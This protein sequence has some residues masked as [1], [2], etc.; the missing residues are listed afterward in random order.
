M[1]NPGLQYTMDKKYIAKEKKWILKA[2]ENPTELA[3]RDRIATSLGISPI[4]AELL[5]QRGYKN[6][7]SAKNFLYMENEML[8][9][10]FDMKDMDKAVER[11]KKAIDNNEIITVYGDY[12]V[13]G[14][15]SV[16]TL[17]LYL[18]HKGARVSY[19]IPNRA[20]DGYGVSCSAI[21]MLKKNGTSLII[22][23]D[24]GITAIDEVAY[25]KSIGVDF[26]ITDHHECRVDLPDAC[27]VINPHR[28]DC[29]YPFKELAGV[30]V[31]FKLVSAYEERIGGVSKSTAASR[32]FSQYADLVAIGTIADV[33]PIKEENRIIVSYGLKMIEGTTRL[34]L[35]ALMEAAS[36]RNDSRDKPDKKRKRSKITTSYIGYTLAPRINAAGRIRSATLAVELFLSEDPVESAKIANELCLANKERQAE[37]NKIMEEAYEKIESLGMDKDSV[38][39]L[40]ADG[41]HHGVIGIVASRITEKYSRPTIL[42]SFDSVDG[43]QTDSDVGKG[44]GRSIKGL[45]LVDALYHCSEHLVKFGGHELAAGLSVTRGSLEQ[46]RKKIN[47]YANESLDEDAMIPTLE[48]DCRVNLNEISIGLAENLQILEPFGVGNPVPVFAMYNVNL[49]EIT[50]VSENKHS[51]LTIGEGRHTVSAMYFSNSPDSIGVYNG[52]RVDLMFNLD[53]NEWQGRRSVQLVVKDIRQAV[54]LN[55]KKKSEKARFNEIWQGAQYT[56][57]ENVLPCRDDFAVVYKF[58]FASVRGGQDTLTSREIINGISKIHGAPTIGYV[59]I[60]IILKVFRELNIIG[61]DELSDESY[62]FKV[63]YSSTKTDLEKS[64]LLR[65]I[66]SQLITKN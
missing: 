21:D 22:T 51:R 62:R 64:T 42:I 13:D 1:P 25:A 20:G 59:K 45:N 57:D 38:I 36:S 58:I 5:Y 33:M 29:P 60:K 8:C 40:D 19:Y 65:R 66:R 30:G 55:E 12:D 53:I 28:F 15:T 41:W 47:E 43:N 54:T 48:A 2:L 26:L 39:V 24:T 34:G 56:Q 46:F 49:A 35:I 37:E 7:T 17:Y 52:E 61:I 9:N 27:A 6:P 16:C 3:A 44:S 32:I 31:V 14:V 11:I 10:P 50:G 18:K 4:V 23:V 63:H